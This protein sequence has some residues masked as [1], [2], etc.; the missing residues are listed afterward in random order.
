[1]FLLEVTSSLALLAM[2]LDVILQL[3]VGI[4]DFK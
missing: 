4:S 1:M 2:E 3:A